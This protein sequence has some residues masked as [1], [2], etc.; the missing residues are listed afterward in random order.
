[1]Y[2]VERHIIVK[3]KEMDTICFL[4]KNLYNYVN[5]ILRQVYT[6]NFDSII[7]YKHL[8]KSFKIKDKEYFKIDE[9]DLVKELAKNNQ[10]DYRSLSSQ[11]AQR[12]VFQVYQDWNFGVW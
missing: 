8:I 1:M 7:E 6:K 5:F 3:S 2:R 11:A 4:S 12:V 9:Y 10:V